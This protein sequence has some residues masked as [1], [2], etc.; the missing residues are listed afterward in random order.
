M[1]AVSPSLPHKF[2]CRLYSSGYSARPLRSAPVEHCATP[3]CP[4]QKGNIGQEETKEGSN[5]KSAGSK[6]D[7]ANMSSQD[8]VFDWHVQQSQ[9][10]PL[11]RLS[12]A[13]TVL[14]NSM[15]TVIGPTP[16]GTGL[17]ASAFSLTASKSIS[18]TSRFP[19]LE[20]G[21]SM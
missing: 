15:V 5:T 19:V 1:V 2:S 17:I 11:I 18:P 21:S 9:L 14:T 20:A 8:L 13:V 12:A 16:P 3:R 7:K 6:Q 10:R 4:R